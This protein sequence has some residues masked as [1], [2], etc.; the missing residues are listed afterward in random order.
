[1]TAFLG[2]FSLVPSWLY[3]IL[4]AGAM[5]TNCAT[6]NRLDTEKL[7]HKDLQLAVKD[8]KAEAAQTLADETAKVLATERKLTD[9][10][11]LQEKTDAKNSQL[12]RD[13]RTRTA[14]VS[15]RDPGATECR[16][17]GGSAKTPTAAVAGSGGA[18]GSETAGILSADF[19]RLLW[20]QGAAADEINIAFASCKAYVGVLREA[21]PK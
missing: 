17:S 21:W 1:M 4:L 12:V 7:A 3:A 14:S 18:S 6:S 9:A 5:A 8:Q 19:A 11:K 13:L 20:D 2:I 16:A 15:L 10:L